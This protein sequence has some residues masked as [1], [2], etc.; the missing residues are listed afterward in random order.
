MTDPFLRRKWERVFYTFFDINKNQSIDW[1]DFEMLFEKIKKLRGEESTEYKIASDAMGA[2]WRGLLQA[3]KGI[4]MTEEVASDVT[5]SIGEWDKIWANFNPNH[6]H[7]WQW[8]YLKYMFFLLDATG[9]KYIDADEY[10]EVMQIYGL[11]K[12]ESKKAFNIFSKMPGVKSMGV[13][14]GSFVKLW[15]QFFTSHDKKAPGNCLFG[16]M[17]EI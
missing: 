6:M 14:Y 1:N 16:I 11:K 5:I 9:D 2:V 3:T 7:I 10:C 12:E 15:N 4:D 8:E 17:E 13:D